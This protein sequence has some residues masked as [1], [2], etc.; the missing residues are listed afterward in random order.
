VEPMN[1]GRTRNQLKSRD[2]SI[3]LLFY[4]CVLSC[5]LPSASPTLTLSPALVTNVKLSGASKTMTIVLPS[6]NPPISSPAVKG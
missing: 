3:Q 5:T 6:M 2:H 4:N 1:A